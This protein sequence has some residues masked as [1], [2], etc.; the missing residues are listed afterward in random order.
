MYPVDLARALKMGTAAG[1]SESLSTLLRNFINTYGYKGLFTQGLG[2]ELARASA[3]RISKFFFFP[4]VHQGLFGT[5]EAKGTPTSKAISGAFAVLPESIVISGMEVSKIALQ[6]D[7]TNE[8]KNSMGRALKHVQETRG[9]AGQF[10]AYPTLLYRQAAWTSG[11]FASLGSF[12]TMLNPVFGIKKGDKPTGAQN[13]LAGFL[14]GVL[15]A[16][17]NTPGDVIRT[18]ITKEALEHPPVRYQITPSFLW[19]GV[20]YS[21][22]MGQRIVASRGVGGLWA[23]FG[24]KAIHL[25]GSGALMAYFIPIYTRWLFPSDS[26]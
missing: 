2:P 24:I 5:P 23:G 13:T 1:K 3:M 21:V 12:K 26:E 22:T 8:F 11:Y 14:A 7:K 20:T 16:C 4:I 18:N 25:G 19:S 9:I 15:G 17:F 6:F 10:I